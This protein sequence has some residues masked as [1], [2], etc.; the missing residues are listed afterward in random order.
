MHGSEVKTIPASI[1]P[2]EQSPLGAGSPGTPS[3]RV[4]ED[5]DVLVWLLGRNERPL[6][7]LR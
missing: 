1:V 5:F 7:D 2:D 4:V 6:D 3:F